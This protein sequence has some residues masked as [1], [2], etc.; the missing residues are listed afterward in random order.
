MFQ[1]IRR[2]AIAAVSA[3]TLG[4]GAAVWVTSSASAAPAATPACSAASLSVWVDGSQSNGAAG[5]VEY[6]LEFT[7][8]TGK[9]C[10]LYGY[11]GVSAINSSGKQLGDAASRFALFTKRTVTIPAGGT[12]HADLFYS[13]GE[14]FTAP[15]CKRVTASQIKVFAPNTKKAKDGFFDLQVCS[16]AKHPYLRI[17]VVR[18]GPRID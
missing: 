16:A 15:G 13:D 10:T 11:P 17:S 8:I 1:G 6:P 18:P 14:V 9:A 3:L 5:S 12:A 2:A 4:V 7:N